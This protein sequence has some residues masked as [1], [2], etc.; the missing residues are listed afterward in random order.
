MLEVSWCEL[1]DCL[2]SKVS[3]LD[4]LIHQH[5]RYLHRVL[6][7][8]LLNSKAAPVMKIITDIFGTI[9]RFSSLAGQGDEAWE[10]LEKLYRSFSVYSRWLSVSLAL[11]LLNVP[12]FRIFA[13]HISNQVHVPW[14]LLCCERFMW[15]RILLRFL[16]S[17]VGKLSA[18][19]YQS[20]LQVSICTCHE[21]F[22]KCLV[23]SGSCPEAQ[24]QRLLWLDPAFSVVKSKDNKLKMKIAIFSQNIVSAITSDPTQMW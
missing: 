5:E 24:L 3:C 16:Y 19:G 21:L 15:F 2:R 10:E 23:F 20:H 14:L 9:T 18:R 7:R 1:Q 13:E 8:C 11:L 22:L 6:F 4:D 17:V 12:A